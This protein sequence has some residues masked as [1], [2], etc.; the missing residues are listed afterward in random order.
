VTIPFECVY[1]DEIQISHSRLQSLVDIYGERQRTGLI[2]LASSHAQSI[3]LL[4]QRGVLLNAYL[5]GVAGSRRLENWTTAAEEIGEGFARVV[6]LSPLALG[7]CKLAIES[8]ET[9]TETISAAEL[10]SSLIQS[11]RQTIEPQ[12]LHLRWQRAEG[13]VFYQGGI[14]DEHSVF[15]SPERL[16][17]E[18]GISSALVLWSEAESAL[19]R[20]VITLD[21]PAWQEYVLRRTFAG[22]CNRAL[23]R[24]EEITG[25][26]IVDSI[27]RSLI[28]LASRLSLEINIA[29]R[30]VID[31]EVFSTPQQ[32]ADGY[33]ALLQAML[34][35]VRLII[36]SPL[37]TSIILDITTSLH[38]SELQAVQDFSLLPPELLQ[39]GKRSGE[40]RNF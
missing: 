26:A 17:D 25:T 16:A 28:L 38:L 36:G 24:Y 14:F 9:Q 8:P 39:E 31:R 27:I 11:W 30:R 2:R 10:R 1:P 5:A 18:A 20:Y 35:Q 4:F 33:R 3:Y 21:T 37:S 12:L 7:M 15:F 23:L 22:I 32:A 29:S 40:A 6:Q 19:T 34:D 13:L